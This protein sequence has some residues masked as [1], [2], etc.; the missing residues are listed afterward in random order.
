MDT[1]VFKERIFMT[2]AQKDILDAIRPLYKKYEQSLASQADWQRFRK[3]KKYGAIQF[4]KWYGLER[5]GASK[6]QHITVVKFLNKY[7]ECLNS[8]SEKEIRKNLKEFQDENLN[9][10]NNPLFSTEIANLDIPF[11][12]KYVENKH[13]QQAYESLI[14]QRGVGH[15]IASLF[16]R[17]VSL[18]LTSL[19]LTE[20]SLQDTL[21][22]FPVDVWVYE[23]MKAFDLKSTSTVNVLRP[24]N[25]DKEKF[26]LS[27]KFCIECLNHGYDPRIIN[28]CIWKFGAHYAGNIKRLE[29]VIKEGSNAINE[30]IKLIDEF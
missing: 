5:S 27:Q 11:I 4:F 8:M 3:E 7:F 6:E 14:G 20:L 15:K 10:N 22:L 16:L 29:K 9:E 13:F 12:I 1:I 2:T 19:K 30:E 18:K 21:Y 28:V 24:K 23:F 26:E 25:F 17:D